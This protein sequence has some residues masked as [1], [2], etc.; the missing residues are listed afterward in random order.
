MNTLLACVVAAGLVILIVQIVRIWDETKRAT[1]PEALAKIID[2][3]PADDT[4]VAHVYKISAGRDE[5]YDQE[6]HLEGDLAKWEKEMR[7]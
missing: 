4:W 5:V 7:A 6:M 3:P 2:G 1:T